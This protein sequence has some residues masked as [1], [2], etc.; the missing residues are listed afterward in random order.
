MVHPFVRV[1]IMDMRTGKY[2]AKR[3]PEQPGVANL[4]SSSLIDADGN[5]TSKKVDYLLPV[6]TKFFDMRKNGKNACDWN[7]EFIINE[8]ASYIC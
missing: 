3:D 4:E 2:L 7:E 1:H 8:Y 6:S 5:I